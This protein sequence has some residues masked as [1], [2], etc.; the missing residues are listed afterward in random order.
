M[1]FL[2]RDFGQLSCLASNEMGN[3]K[4]ACTFKLIAAGPPQPPSSCTI[5]NQTTDLLQVQGPP[6]SC[7]ILNQ[8]TDLLQVQ[9]PPSSCTIPNQ[10]T[11]LLQVQGPPSSCTI[12]NQTTYWRYWPLYTLFVDFK[13]FS[14]PAV[15]FC[16]PDCS[17]P[18]GFS[19]S[20][21]IAGLFY[22]NLQRLPNVK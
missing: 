4:E 17:T 3:M 7:T 13:I 21:Y 10:T 15:Y 14:K 9:G 2:C 16:K 8:T 19:S 12:L 5:L 18:R 6:S 1:T 20:S 11:D 22:C